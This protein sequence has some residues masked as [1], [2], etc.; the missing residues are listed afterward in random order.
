ML[1]IKLTDNRKKQTTSHTDV[2]LARPAV[3]TGTAGVAGI[4]GTPAPAIGTTGPAAGT[5]SAAPGITD[6]AAG[7]TEA[8]GI[9]ATAPA[10]PEPRFRFDGGIMSAGS[11]TGTGLRSSAR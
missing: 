8:A 11:V 7:N 4:N 6:D 2:G 5:G 3:G 9:T 10:R 1:K